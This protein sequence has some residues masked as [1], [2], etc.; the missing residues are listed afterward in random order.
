MAQ[1]FPTLRYS[2]TPATQSDAILQTEHTFLSFLP[3]CHR[4][5]LFISTKP[6]G[7]TCKGR[8][9]WDE[10]CITRE[11][12]EHN[13]TEQEQDCLGH[14][15]RTLQGLWVSGSFSDICQGQLTI[16]LFVVENKWVGVERDVMRRGES[17]V[18]NEGG[19]WWEGIIYQGPL[20]HASLMTVHDWFTHT[21]CNL[22]GDLKT[23]DNAR[24][25]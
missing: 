4:A 17:Y 16:L 2:W 8:V 6:A 9:G 20:H 5:R 1:H 14:L 25:S 3:S 24:V 11:S 23:C 18:W 12:E 15:L 7:F 13:R 21:L 19:G 22:Q 10:G